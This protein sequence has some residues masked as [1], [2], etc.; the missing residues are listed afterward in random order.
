MF[1]CKEFWFE[2]FKKR[3]DNLKT[4]NRGIYVL[5]DNAFRWIRNLHAIGPS[6]EA[7][8][9]ALREYAASY[10]HFPCGIIRGLLNNLV[11]MRI[12]GRVFGAE[13]LA[14][15]APRRAGPLDDSSTRALTDASEPARRRG[16]GGGNPPVF[17]TPLASPQ[18]FFLRVPKRARCVDDGTFVA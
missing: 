8:N 6:E 7:G 13:G 14:R 15:R 2:V 18:R 4:N 12:C 16:D 3:V 10:T 1:L 5:Q 17:D 11:R 9:T